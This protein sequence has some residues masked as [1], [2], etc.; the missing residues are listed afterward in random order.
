MGQKAKEEEEEEAGGGWCSSQG[1]AG[2]KTA[3]GLMNNEPCGNYDIIS[4][5]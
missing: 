4:P 5:W 1:A 3:D 2:P